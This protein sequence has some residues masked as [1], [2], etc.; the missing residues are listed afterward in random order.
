M[1]KTHPVNAL[2]KLG[3]G[4]AFGAAT[5]MSMPTS[6]LA[7]T[8][9][10]MG[11]KLTA[12]GNTYYG[13][14]EDY[15][16]RYLKHF[17]IEPSFGPGHTYSSDES[18]F[19][20]T[21]T[22]T[23]YRYTY[24][25]DHPSQWDERWDAYS[26]A[27]INEKGVSCSATLT[28]YMNAAAKAADPLTDTGIGEYS[29]GSVILGESATAR[30][31]VELLGK[32]IDDQGACGNDQIIISDNNETWLFAALSGH[33]WIA[34]K[35]TDDIA[36]LN[37]NIGN[38]N[39]KVDL[40]DTE[41]CLHSEGIE[42]MPKEKGFAKYFDD[43]QFDV[44][45]T[46]GEEISENA[47]HS[48]ARYV[49]GR[50]YFDAPLTEGTD[51]KIVKDTH[52]NA[53]ATTGA[54]P[55]EAQP[56][57]FQPGKSNWNTFEMIR[58]FGNRGEKAPGLNA[59]TDGAYAIGTESNSEI[60]LFQ[61]RDGL[62]P[63]IATIQWEM[64]SRAAYSVAIPF[65]SA[66][67]TEVSPYFSDQ[68]VS[69]DHCKETDIVNN[70][71]PENSINYVLMDISSLCFEHP[72]LLGVNVRTYLDALQNELVEQNLEVDEVMQATEGTEARTAL[73]NKAGNAATEN[74]YVKCKA[75]LQEMRA[76]LKA[77]NFDQPFTPSDLNTETNGLK[78]SITYA[79]DALATDP[80]TPDQPGTPE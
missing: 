1:R 5:I 31:G 70:E 35:L 18:A 13:R 49:Q 28:T 50:A 34:M 66:L 77:E 30:E 39:Y 43:G 11:N 17:G 79:K 40:N 4:L 3:I 38:L 61:I 72:E 65:Y 63:E 54:L 47:M 75:L 24:V 9:I 14:A 73:A 27:G 41:N 26:E 15:R 57:F 60:N 7:C 19:V 32:I 59:N 20:Y 62:D 6:A 33:Q 68:T 53:R 78:V 21:S 71:E 42:S 56:L 44:A 10:Y 58:A 69:Y 74:T 36:S 51:Y 37:P 48:W 55:F 52:E 25:R 64:L 80:V 2:K 12:D 45:Q 8:Q 76:Y 46:Y 22:K 16:K 23:S 67:L 29:Y